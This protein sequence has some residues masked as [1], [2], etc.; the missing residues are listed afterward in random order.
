VG[1]SLAAFL[2]ASILFIQVPGPSLLFTIGRALTVGRSEALLSVIGNALGLL[3]QIACLAV[4]LGAVVAASAEAFTVLKLV[5]A[6]YVV[7]LGVQAIR[8]RSDSRTALDA[9]EVATRS[10]GWSSVRTGMV[11]GTTN[12]KTIVFF[13]AFLPQFVDDSKPAAPQLLVLGLV[14]AAMAAASDSCWALASSRAKAW[15]ARKP[16]RLDRLGATGGVMMIG[17]GAALATTGNQG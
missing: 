2:V 13:A 16:H 8:H 4:G 10:R 14:F 15:F 5:G 11:V 7:Y 3:V 17:L 6:A 1:H 12:P 9:H